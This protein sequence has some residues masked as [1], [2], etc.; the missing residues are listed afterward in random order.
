MEKLAL[1]T[2]G[3]RGIGAAISVALKNQGLTVIANF[4]S[5]REAAENFEKTWEIKTKQWNVANLSECT[6]A[7]QEIEA[8]YDQPI[9]ILVNNAGITKDTMMHKM[10]EEDW[11]EVINV[12]LNSCFNMCASV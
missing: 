10:R 6:K 11:Q 3:T 5:N 1:V 4:Y 12:N 7:V 2:G 9:S 8:E